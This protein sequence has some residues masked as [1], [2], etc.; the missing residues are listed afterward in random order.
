MLKPAGNLF[1]VVAPGIVIV[2][3]EST[4]NHFLFRL[5]AGYDIDLGNIS[6][7]PTVNLDFVEGEESLV[8]GISL[9]KGF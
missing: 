3:E 1:F 8:F 6:L 4:D 5:G 7:T 9:G 2:D